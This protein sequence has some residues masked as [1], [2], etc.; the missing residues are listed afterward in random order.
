MKSWFFAALLG[1][2]CIQ[3]QAAASITAGTVSEIRVD[4]DGRGFVVFTE[5]LV[6][7]TCATKKNALS[8]DLAKA[9]GREVYAMVMQA[10]AANAK[11]TA[12]GL[13]TCGKYSVVEEWSSGFIH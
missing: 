7:S 13:G 10:K 8:F 12:E 5:N 9:S 1:V 11:I 6:N 3:A 2:C 4:A